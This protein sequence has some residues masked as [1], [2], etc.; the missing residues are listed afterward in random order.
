M[1]KLVATDIAVVIN[2]V[3]LSDHVVSAE[4][5]AGVDEVEDTAFGQG[6]HSYIGGLENG[7]VSITFQQDY[8]AASIYHTIQPLVGTTTSCVIY[9]NG[10]TLSGTNPRSSATILISDWTPVGGQVGDLQTQSVTWPVS[11]TV[12]YATA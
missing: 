9:P 5:S 7:S 10:T 4:F 2:G 1:A 6:G 11:G 3:D 8:A 12:T